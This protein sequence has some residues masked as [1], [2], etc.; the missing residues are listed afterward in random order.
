M[1]LTSTMRAA[2][3]DYAVNHGRNWKA[4]LREEWLRDT[5]QCI[6]LRQVRN[7]VGPSGLSRISKQSLLSDPVQHAEG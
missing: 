6:E 1:H 7:A 2:L 5:P 3:A 4:Q